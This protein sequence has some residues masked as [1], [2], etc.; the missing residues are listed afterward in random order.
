MVCCHINPDDMVGCCPVFIG[1]INKTAGCVFY[2]SGVSVRK[3][4]RSIP[5]PLHYCTDAT[6]VL[7]FS[8]NSDMVL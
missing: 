7:S 1:G 4:N 6:S 5:S 8:C 2:T 3:S